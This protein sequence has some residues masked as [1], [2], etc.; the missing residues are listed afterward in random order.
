[1]THAESQELL[2]DLA[3]G[4]LDAE[5]AAEVATHVEGCADCREEKA[6]IEEARRIAAPLRELEEPSAG[7]DERI[8]AS[9]RAQ[10]QL[11]HDGN[12]GQVIEV[13]GTVRP[14]GMDAAHI[15]AHGP[16]RARP[17]ERQ[18]P[19]WLM[20]AALGGSVAAAAALA[21]VVSTTLETRRNR[22]RVAAVRSDEYK[23][24]VGPAAPQ[25]LDSALRDA[26]SKRER[27]QAGSKKLEVA[28]PLQLPA[29]PQQK[30]KAAQP[31][32]KAPRQQAAGSGARI[33]GAGGE[34]ASRPS[35]PAAA[36]KSVA[37]PPEAHAPMA[38]NSPQAAPVA[39]APEVD[40]LTEI[41]GT[42][43]RAMKTAPASPAVPAP[44][45]VAA[46]AGMLA[47]GGVEASAQQARHAG[48][49]V[50]AASLYR[51][52]AD[53]RRRDNDL[54]AAAWDLAHAVECLSAVA[55]FDEARAVRDELARAYPSETGALSA[56]RRALREVDPP[57]PAMKQR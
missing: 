46:S 51:Q 28:P 8:L 55:Q 25:A 3:Y 37:P 6:A 16:V 18:R 56:A 19:R 17:T 43:S 42:R 11:E 53:L 47:A 49:Y 2:I 9:A 14:L 27:E 21:L 45:G 30:D 12:V 31:R 40:R 57:V 10:A 26:D 39:S 48:D 22:E 15:D 29:E 13:T 32:P 38:K 33:E 54:S 52:A 1:M 4:E 50:L 34:V 5:R 36:A 35:P 24:Q 20:R 23:I 7:F 44:A 41:S